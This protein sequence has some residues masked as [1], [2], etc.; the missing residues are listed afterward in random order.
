VDSSIRT[1]ARGDVEAVTLV[2]R[3]AFHDHREAAG[4][5]VDE[6]NRYLSEP[7]FDA[8]GLFIAD[9]DGVVGFCWTRVHP[10]GDGE[11][12]RIAVNPSHQCMAVGRGL[13]QAG[14]SYLDADPQVRRGVLW[15]DRSNTQAISLYRSLGM[16]RERS[17]REFVPG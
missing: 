17:I 14:F 13:R 2:N 16:E 11:I 9:Q 15:V 3:A 4:L 12:F 6:M 1:F 5:D 7:W 8:D 10:G